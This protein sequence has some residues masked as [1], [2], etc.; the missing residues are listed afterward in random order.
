MIVLQKKIAATILLAI[1]IKRRRNKMLRKRTW[2]RQWIQRR[3]VDNT[4]QKLMEDLRSE[5][6]G[7]EFERYFRV[8]AEQFDDLLAKIDPIIIKKDTILRQSISPEIRLAITLRYLSSGDSFRSLML[9]F[10][11][12][13]NTISNIISST[14]SAIHSVLANNFLKVVMN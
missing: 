4:G 12:A 1:L 14:C 7:E 8:S 5:P 2:A 9:L 3:N 10:R 11:V 13:H 6:G